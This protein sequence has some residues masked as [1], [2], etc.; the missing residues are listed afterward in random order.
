ML[1]TAAGAAVFAHTELDDDSAQ[2]V[3]AAVPLRQRAKLLS[4]SQAIGDV[5]NGLH[6][7]GG[8][9]SVPQ[10]PAT[11]NEELIL[12]GQSDRLNVGTRDDGGV[13]EGVAHD[14]C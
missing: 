11:Q 13:K 1:G 5:P 3:G 10:A 12:R 7:F 8:G 9:D 14:P 4:S 6:S 2:A